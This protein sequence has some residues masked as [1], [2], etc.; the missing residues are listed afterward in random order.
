MNIY[1]MLGRR[2]SLVGMWPVGQDMITCQPQ[3][4]LG[5]LSKLGC[6]GAD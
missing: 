4:R 6:Y 3:G 5:G 1:G 2:L